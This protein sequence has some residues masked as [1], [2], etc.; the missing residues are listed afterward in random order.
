MLCLGRHK[1]THLQC[2]F[3]CRVCCCLGEISAGRSV[4]DSATAVYEQSAFVDKAVANHFFEAATL[5]AH[6]GNEQ[7]ALGCY[8]AHFG[9][10]C[11]LSCT[12]HEHEILSGTPFLGGL[13][14][15]F[16]EACACH[17]GQELEVA[18]AGVG[19]QGKEDHP[20][21]LRSP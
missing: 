21:C 4:D 7:E 10:H 2:E 13:Q 14:N 17:V 9:K 3:F 1:L 15:V 16:E 6:A 19:G 18:A 20:L 8:T 12:D 11:A 5:S